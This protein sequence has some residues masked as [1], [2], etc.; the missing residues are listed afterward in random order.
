VAL[1]L[2]SFGTGAHPHDIVRH[3]FVIFGIVLFNV[4]LCAPV[5]RTT[6][7]DFWLHQQHKTTQAPAPHSRL[8]GKGAGNDHFQ[9]IQ[10]CNLRHRSRHALCHLFHHPLST[11]GVQLP[12]WPERA[13]Q[14]SAFFYPDKFTSSATFV[15]IRPL[16]TP[17]GMSQARG[18]TGPE[19]KADKADESAVS[20]ASRG[21]IGSEK[22]RQGRKAGQKEGEVKEETAAV[23]PK[24]S[25]MSTLIKKPRD[26]DWTCAACNA[27]VFDTYSITSTHTY[28]PYPLS[29]TH[30]HKCTH[31]YTHTPPFLVPFFLP[32]APLFPLSLSPLSLSLSLAPLSLF[33]SLFTLSLSFALSHA[34]CSMRCISLSLAPYP[35]SSL[36]NLSLSRCSLSH[37][38]ALSLMCV[39]ACAISFLLFLS[40]CLSYSLSHTHIHIHACTHTH[41]HT[42]TRTRARA[43]TH[44]CIHP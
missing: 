13:C 11:N 26:G 12:L 16:L 28:E 15:C 43:N 35:L 4:L 37:C 32:L 30:R 21:R 2:I 3:R 8:T 17:L 41:M 19:E 27:Q 25:K 7:C 31:I 24:T 20:S 9:R 34:R 29:H 40:L 5:A 33:C 23:G 39:V 42:Y 10:T 44:K 1:S 6:I 38:R 14:S 18:E 36:L 22:D